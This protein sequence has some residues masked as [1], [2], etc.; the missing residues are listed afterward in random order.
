MAG[1]PS[2][3]LRRMIITAQ[4][5]FSL[6]VNGALWLDEAVSQLQYKETMSD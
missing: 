4:S 6:I 1:L 3:E 2:S 5:Q